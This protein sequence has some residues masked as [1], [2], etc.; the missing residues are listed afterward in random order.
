VN[1]GIGAPSGRGRLAVQDSMSRFTG[2]ECR[3]YK[4]IPAIYYLT[5]TLI[6]TLA[7]RFYLFKNYYT[8]NNDGILYIHSI[9]LYSRFS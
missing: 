6:L 4:L 7:V 3:F 5:G 2:P 1:E 9:R 8:I